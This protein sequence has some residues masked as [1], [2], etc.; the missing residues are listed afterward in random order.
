MKARINA[1]IPQELSDKLD[2]LL[3]WGVK[4]LLIRALLE[5][6]VEAVEEHGSSVLGLIIDK[7]FNPLT[8][9]VKAEAKL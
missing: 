8:K 4:S 7:R 3:P 2:N 1:E 6:A 9:E 5:L